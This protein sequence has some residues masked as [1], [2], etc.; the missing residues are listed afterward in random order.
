MV[1]ICS[2][3]IYFT[4]FVITVIMCFS[5]CYMLKSNNCDLHDNASIHAD[6][7]IKFY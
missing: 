1:F 6:I 3:K 2:E 5:M 4:G 7:N